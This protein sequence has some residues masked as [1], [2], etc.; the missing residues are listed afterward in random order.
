MS[1]FDLQPTHPS[2]VSEED[3]FM[4]ALNPSPTRFLAS[5]TPELG[6]TTGSS[7]VAGR[8]EILTPASPAGN[9]SGFNPRALQDH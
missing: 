4:R 8:F 5:A 2:F 3:R 7:S 9:R 1:A 6:S